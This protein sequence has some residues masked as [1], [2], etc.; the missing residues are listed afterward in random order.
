[1]G[2]RIWKTQP[3][4]EEDLKTLEKKHKNFTEVKIDG[5]CLNRLSD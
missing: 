5:V 2:L 3:L 1:M 4:A